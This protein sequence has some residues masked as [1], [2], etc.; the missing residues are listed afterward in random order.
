MSSAPAPSRRALFG[1]GA[2]LLAGGTIKATVA[3]GA[4]A[5][6]DAELIAASADAARS[7]AQIRIINRL[8]GGDIAW[9][10]AAG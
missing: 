2:A 4:P 8:H 7:Y 5:I 1:A 3:R 9:L 10:G 6:A